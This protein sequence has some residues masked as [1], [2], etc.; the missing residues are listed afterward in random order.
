[1]NLEFWRKKLED[2]ERDGIFFMMEN[3]M[4][5]SQEEFLMTCRE[6]M[7]K[8]KFQEVFVDYNN[9][10]EDGEI[11]FIRKGIIVI[12]KKEKRE[13]FCFLQTVIE[14][15]PHAFAI[16][17]PPFAI[18]FSELKSEYK[19]LKDVRKYMEFCVCFL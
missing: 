9:Q 14:G 17:T 18:G 12:C 7:E 8:N 5:S 3:S 16:K 13:S 4:T 10:K 6:W 1:M 2:M 11:H 15:N 19:H